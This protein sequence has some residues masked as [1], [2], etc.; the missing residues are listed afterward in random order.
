MKNISDAEKNNLFQKAPMVCETSDFNT[1]QENVW[2][3][4]NSEPIFSYFQYLI[5]VY[6]VIP[7]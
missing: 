2:D 4:V 6:G 3:M 7:V 1:H 5:L